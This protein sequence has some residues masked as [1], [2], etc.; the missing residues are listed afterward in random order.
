LWILF[1][2]I[3]DTFDFLIDREDKAQVMGGSLAAPWDQFGLFSLES[4]LD[5]STKDATL[6]LR[7][8]FHEALRYEKQPIPAKARL[9][10]MT[11]S[12]LA[13]L[14]TAM[15]SKPDMTIRHLDLLQVITP[16]FSEWIVP[17]SHWLVCIF[18]L[19]TS[20]LNS[21]GRD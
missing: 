12:E 8:W 2:K 1:Q 15:S 20:C 19:Y 3:S 13:S 10:A 6:I 9:G 7:K 4:L 5:K 18:D 14:Q 21:K 16:D 17:S 11:S